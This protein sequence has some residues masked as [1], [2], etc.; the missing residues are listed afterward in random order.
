MNVILKAVFDS[1]DDA[2][3]AIAALHRRGVNVSA[4]KLF[5]NRQYFSETGLIDDLSHF[6]RLMPGSGQGT[7]HSG[8]S[9]SAG[10]AAGALGNTLLQISIPS[11]EAEAA[12]A[13]LVS[14]HGRRLSEI[15]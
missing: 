5:P 9:R 14:C 12:R 6:A 2:D 10:S 4:M 13:C 11:D 1:P 7:L 15:N 3:A 8:G